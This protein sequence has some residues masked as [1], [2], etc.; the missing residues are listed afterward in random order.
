M[1]R[2]YIIWRN[3]HT[4]DERLGLVVD[5][6]IL[7]DAAKRPPDSPGRTIPGAVPAAEIP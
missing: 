7:S 5:R 2:R 4:Y 1:I 3:D 6:Q